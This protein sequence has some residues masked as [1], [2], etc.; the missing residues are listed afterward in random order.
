[1]ASVYTGVTL[2]G[3]YISFR[4]LLAE[5]WRLTVCQG[6]HECGTLTG[7]MLC[8][9]GAGGGLLELELKHACNM[10]GVVQFPR[11]AASMCCSLAAMP[12]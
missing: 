10:K 11:Y 9:V 2:V 12:R 7:G 8:S 6:V 4:G 3:W 1:M 5:V